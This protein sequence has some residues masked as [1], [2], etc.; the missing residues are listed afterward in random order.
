MMAAAPS[1]PPVPFRQFVLKVHSRCDLACDHCY[2]YE[3]ADQSW[4][5]R[6][7]ELDPATAAQVSGRI[8]QHAAAH[9]LTEVRV[10]LHGGE[11]LLV[12]PRRM[13]EILAA[14]D[15][16]VS[17]IARLDLRIHTN[18]VLLD[19][20]FLDVFAEYGVRIGVS[21]D[22]DRAANDR[23]RRYRDGRSSFDQV[24]EALA[25]LRRPEYR[26]LYAGLLCTVDIANDPA[27]VYR[28]LIEQQPPRVDL[29]LPHATWENQPPGFAAP[30][31]PDRP[32]EGAGEYAR[33]L[34]A[35]FDLWDADGRPM[36]I[37]TFDSILAALYGRPVATEALG[38]DPVDLLVIETD[39]TLEQV[40]SLKIA[41]EGA[42]ATGLDVW[43]NE[44]DDAFAVP[45]I[46]VRQQGVDGV[47]A[48]CRA[49]PL[50][51]TCGGGLYPHRFRP[52]RG[53]DNPS[54]YCADLIRMIGHVME[55]ESSQGRG[56]GPH[57]EAVP[58]APEAADAGMG[59]NEDDFGSLAMG[60]GSAAAVG[61][62]ARNQA[63]LQRYLL[64]RV[65]RYGPQDDRRFTQAWDLLAA[66][67]KQAP[68]AVADVF[69]L[70]YTR[71]WA[72]DLLNS[73]DRKTASPY[74][75]HHL[76]ALSASAA[77]RAGHDV[78]VPVPVRN[79]VAPLPGFGALA[80]GSDDHVWL[81]AAALRESEIV[82]PLRRVDAAGLR[83]TIED[84][85]PYR[86]CHGHPAARLS[87][88]DAD[89]W[90]KAL[91]PAVAYIDEHLP[92]FAPGL[93]AG[94]STVMPM[95][96]PV[97]GTQRS[98]AA[99]H[100]FGAV[101]LALPDDPVQLAKLLVH[102][103][104]HVKLGALLDIGELYDVTDTEPRYYAPWRSDP[105]PIEGLLQG[106]YAHIAVVAFWRTRR[107]QLTGEE[108]DTAQ[109]QFARWRMHTAE[110]VEQLHKASSLTPLGWKFTE[111]MGHTLESWL[112]EPVDASALA[113]ARRV[114]AE[115]RAGF[116]MRMRASTR[117]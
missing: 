63:E 50:V 44:L 27:A 117:S 85:D 18:A 26:R 51:Q 79:G 90:A 52:G 5:G 78:R 91:P 48:V 34:G 8:A 82:Q 72:V 88:A 86:D 37:R 31:D 96:R 114:A 47:S 60:Y 49:C 115:H 80:A 54:V 104:Q 61:I 25:R 35:I 83:I 108:R 13:R 33:W 23:H 113:E 32:T 29:L 89:A 11:P 109:I 102:E 112:R 17:P 2:V 94:L 21:L 73:L 110:G 28:G 53:F 15:A 62:L 3:H 20:D 67:S 40:D 75:V 58:R 22:G 42:A 41:Y 77:A 9:R 57:A 93:R 103:F 95:I 100:A 16:A 105:R 98:A 99:R 97:D 84:T 76:E 69:A 19:E 12:G 70:P 45:G 39:G 74:D 87:S 107:T 59:L 55:T 66:L 65:A 92:E 43:R 1:H 38:L 36:S 81:D 56:I 4:R 68:E 6:P 111:A 46:A 14:L 30:R 101:G 116:E 71:V 10:V 106:T 64:A 7:R 24:A